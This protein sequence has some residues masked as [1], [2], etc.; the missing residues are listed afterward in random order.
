M[1][2]T[3]TYSI[4]YNAA[5]TTSNATLYT[6]SNGDGVRSV[7]ALNTSGSAATISVTVVRKGGSPTDNQAVVLAAALSVPAGNATELIASENLTSEYGEL[8]LET[9]DY[10][11]G[12]Q[13]TGSAITLIVTGS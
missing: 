2:E 11:Y 12:A 9:G 7:K 6:S 1:P 8:L 10:L 13:G 3:N 5:P 4:L